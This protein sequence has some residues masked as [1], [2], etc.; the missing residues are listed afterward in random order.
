MRETKRPHALITMLMIALAL[1]MTACTETEQGGLFGLGIE[2]GDNFDKVFDTLAKSTP[3]TDERY[4]DCYSEENRDSLK[5]IIVHEKYSNI[6]W[7]CTKDYNIND[8]KCSEIYL[9]FDSDLRLTKVTNIIGVITGVDSKEELIKRIQENPDSG[10]EWIIEYLDVIYPKSTRINENVQE[11]RMLD[12]STYIVESF[13]TAT[14]SVIVEKTIGKGWRGAQL[15]IVFEI[16][17]KK[18]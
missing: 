11:E 14:D 6:H 18:E 2:L 17:L 13:A 9:S 8:V 7:F 5:E 4:E 15:L 16:S 10:C 1:I 12:N 3:K